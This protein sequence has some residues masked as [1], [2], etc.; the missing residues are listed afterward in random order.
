MRKRNSMIIL[1]AVLVLATG[2]TIHRANMAK[3][4]KKEMIGMSKVNLLACAGA[5]M[6][7]AVVHGVEYLTYAG[8]GDTVGYAS[9]HPS[10]YGS[11]TGSY[12]SHRRY[13][14]VT[15]VLQNDAVVRINYS[16]RTG[17]LLTKGEQ[18]AFVVENCLS[19]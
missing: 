9:A 11:Y 17:G 2:C 13:C 10:G 16:G 1:L 5:P 14:E 8:G 4:P 15:F 3:R 6:R 12:S 19:E 7:S 18:C